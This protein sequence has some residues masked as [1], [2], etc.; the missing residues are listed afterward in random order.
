M[1]MADYKTIQGHSVGI[2]AT[3]GTSGVGSYFSK[4]DGIIKNTNDYKNFGYFI[5]G[6]DVTDQNI[7]QFNPYLKGRSRIFMHKVP[8]FMEKVFP[9]LTSRFKSY[10]ETG[11]TSIGGISDL[12]VEFASFEGGFNGQQ[13]EIVQS[14]K[15]GTDSLSIS[16]YEQT[17]SPV[18][19]FI[20]TWIT[21]VRDPR[22]GIAH[23]HGAIRDKQIAYAQGNHTAEFIYYVLDPTATKIE[24]ACMFA[25]CFPK[26][27]KKDH[28]NYEKGDNGEVSID[29]E[30]SAQHYESLY[31]NDLAKWYMDADNLSFSYLTFNP[32]AGLD[33]STGM[34][35][36]IISKVDTS[37][38]KGTAPTYTLG[39]QR[40]AKAL[41]TSGLETDIDRDGKTATISLS[42]SGPSYSPPSESSTT[43]SS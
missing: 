35:S 39:L 11:Y 43:S 27:V 7:N 3:S 8:P 18:R 1:N 40:Y 10:L 16:L 15:N 23:Y 34:P 33:S 14:S 19:E 31:I 25:N 2:N 32:N 42:T 21:G 13:F 29:M 20:E 22:S 6:I 9:D 12:E 37:S 28:Y 4:A 5:H 17:G 36:G 38:V 41:G 26:G 30:F 24:Y